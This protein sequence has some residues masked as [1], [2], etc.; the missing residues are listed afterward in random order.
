MLAVAHAAL[1]AALEGEGRY[2]ESLGA[3]N[4]ALRLD[5][6]SYEGNRIAGM[7]SMAL[8]RYDDAIRYFEAATRE[9]YRSTP[10]LRVGNE[11]TPSERHHVKIARDAVRQ[12]PAILN[13]Q[14]ASALP[15][16]AA[17]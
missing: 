17:R 14:T 8:H 2:E 16:R 9:V 11:G 3:C 13:C 12:K 10:P 6:E 1:G 4:A 15:D 5:P 7:C